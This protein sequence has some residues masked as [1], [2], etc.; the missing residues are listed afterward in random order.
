MDTLFSLVYVS[1]QRWRVLEHIRTQRVVCKK[2]N[3]EEEVWRERTLERKYIFHTLLLPFCHRYVLN[4]SE[5]SSWLRVIAY[6]A[7][8]VIFYVQYIYTLVIMFTQTWDIKKG[9]EGIR[10]KEDGKKERKYSL[11]NIHNILFCSV[12]FCVCVSNGKSMR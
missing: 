9:E 8:S 3:G 1:I 12:L 6:I 2:C 11:E 10:D 7:Y 5:T 4:S